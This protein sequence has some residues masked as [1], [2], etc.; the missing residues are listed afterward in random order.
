LL[1]VSLWYWAGNL[2]FRSFSFLLFK[3][4]MILSTS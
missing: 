3:M 1:F 4:D 2:I